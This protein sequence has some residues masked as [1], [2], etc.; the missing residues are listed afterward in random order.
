M[1]NCIHC[2]WEDSEIW[3]CVCRPKKEMLKSL[4]RFDDE[5]TCC[6]CVVFVCVCDW[7]GVFSEA[8]VCFNI[9]NQHFKIKILQ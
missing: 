2:V 6:V 9:P 1:Q 3:P 8:S 5:D 7:C 4:E